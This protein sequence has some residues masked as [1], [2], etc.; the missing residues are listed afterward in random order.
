M[1]RK[2]LARYIIS[3]CHSDLSSLTSR[4]KGVLMPILFKNN[5][6]IVA[7]STRC[8]KCLIWLN[9]FC[10]LFIGI[11][12]KVVVFKFVWPLTG[13]RTTYTYYENK[14]LCLTLKGS[15]SVGHPSVLPYMASL[16]GIEPGIFWQRSL[17]RYQSRYVLSIV[18]CKILV[19]HDLSPYCRDLWTL[20]WL[21][22]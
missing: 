5:K 22:G 1:Y 18:I 8:C 7:M 2:K 19:K 4:R 15:W 20:N 21:N 10:H 9:W 17:V 3:D 13:W 6:R 11:V 12:I 14:H 16:S